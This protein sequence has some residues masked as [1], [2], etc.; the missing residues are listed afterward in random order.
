MTT[1]DILTV[2]SR[3]GPGGSTVL[4]VTGEIDRDSRAFLREAADEA[5]GRGDRRLVLHLAGLDFCD[6]SGLSLF[7]DLHRECATGSGWMRIA[8]AS[9][10]LLEMMRVTNLNRLLAVYDTTEAA[11]AE[12]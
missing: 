1:S 10:V 2:V 7:V 8:A 6:S 12:P 9:P 11:T 4:T 3:E 5:I